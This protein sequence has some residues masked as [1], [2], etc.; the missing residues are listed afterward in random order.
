MLDNR[1]NRRTFLIAA[2]GTGLVAATPG[3]CRAAQEDTFSLPT[4]PYAYDELEPHLDAATMEIH[5]SRHHAAYVRGLNNA[6]RDTEYAQWS[7]EQLVSKLDELP[8]SIRTAVRNMGGGHVNHSLFW[9]SLTS[10]GEGAPGGKLGD[11][12]A[13]AFGDFEA[14]WEKLSAASMSVFG[15]GWGWLSWQ[16]GSGLVIESS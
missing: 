1:L 6:V 5:H 12:I 4:L 8:D 9:K 3:W 2:A 11:A 16:P 14:F 13:A 15:S 10:K 7:V